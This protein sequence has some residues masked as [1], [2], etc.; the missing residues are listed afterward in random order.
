MINRIPIKLTNVVVLTFYLLYALL[1]LM[2]STGSV[3]AGAWADGASASV[4]ADHR[5]ILDQDMHLVAREGQSEHS[6]D[7]FGHILLKKKRAIA[8]SFKEIVTKLFPQYAG[9]AYPEHAFKLSFVLEQM[10]EDSPH[11][12]CGF[13]FLHSGV[14]PPSV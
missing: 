12:P 13:L 14:S 8:P 4:S 1:P 2:Y 7:P 6:S 3:N 5:S 10:S 9:S 11:S